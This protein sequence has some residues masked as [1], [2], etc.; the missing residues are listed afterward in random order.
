MRFFV[1]HD[2]AP[3]LAKVRCPVLALGAELDLQVLPEQNLPGHRGGAQAGREHG[4]HRGTPARAEPPASTRQD[5]AAGR[6]RADRNDHCAGRP[7]RHHGVDPEEDRPGEVTRRRAHQC[8]ISSALGAGV[9][10]LIWSS[11]QRPTRSRLPSPTA[12]ASANVTPARRMSIAEG[13]IVRPIPTC[14]RATAL[15]RRMMPARGECGQEPGSRESAVDGANQHAARHDAGRQDADEED[16]D[17]NHEIG[18]VEEEPLGQV[19]CERGVQRVHHQRG[20]HDREDHLH[21]PDQNGGGA[22]DPR[23]LEPRR[24]ADLVGPALDGRP[25]QQELRDPPR[26]KRPGPCRWPGTAGPPAR[27]GAAPGTGP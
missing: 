17:P 12:S 25:A 11:I 13:T 14:S 15:D 2:P 6:V 23:A 21:Q 7:R 9:G 22:Q 3:A 20:G 24:Q 16:R 5:R 1:L 4:R 27:S 18:E 8:W 19:R 26:K 10:G